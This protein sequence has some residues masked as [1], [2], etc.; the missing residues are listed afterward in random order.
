MVGMSPMGGRAEYV[1]ERSVRQG[2]QRE[3]VTSRA[4]T[5]VQA[6]MPYFSDVDNDAFALLSR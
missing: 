6:G 3:Q 5:E 4:P 2:C 1:L